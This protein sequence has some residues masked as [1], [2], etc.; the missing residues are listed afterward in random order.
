MDRL[1]TMVSDFKKKLYIIDCA[2]HV[3]PCHWTRA[4]AYPLSQKFV[5][6]IITKT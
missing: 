6:E 3:I 4:R 5:E 1:L 2:E